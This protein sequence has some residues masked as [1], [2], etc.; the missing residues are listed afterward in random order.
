MTQA[1]QHHQILVE[2]L[3]NPD[4]WPVCAR[5]L[6]V[7]QTHIS[8]VF[9]L[10]DYAYKLKKPLDLG[11][12][13]FSTLKRRK[14]CSEEEI[15]LNSRLAPDVYLAAVPISGSLESPRPEGAGEPIDWLVKMRRF[16]ADEVLAGQPERLDAPLIRQLAHKIA[17]F[18]AR[19]A[20]LG[21][22]TESAEAFGTPEAVWHPV[23]ENFAQLRHFSQDAEIVGPLAELEAHAVAHY[24]RLRPL[25]EERRAEGH[26][27]ECHGD[28]HL[29]NIVLEQG[30]PLIFDGIEFSPGLRWIDTLNDLAFLLMDLRHVGRADLEN[31]ALD[32]Y[33]ETSGDYLGLPLLPFYMAYRAMVRAKV[34]AIRLSQ[35]DLAGEQQQQLKKECLAYL[36]LARDC[37]HPNPGAIWINHGLSG[38]GKSYCAR[39]LP[40]PLPLVRLCSDIERKRLAGLAPTERARAEI[41]GGL[42]GPEMGRRTFERLLAC[43]RAVALAGRIA[44]VDATFIRRNWRTGFRALAESLGVRFVILS[45]SA[46]EAELECRICERMEQGRDASD[47]TLEVLRSQQ[48]NLEPLSP[49]EAAL[50]IQIPRNISLEEL[51]GDALLGGIYPHQSERT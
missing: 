42:Y 20:R 45:F 27:R 23:G 18:H 29:G 43:A 32:A 51:F 14:F 37:A 6:E 9:L 4:C 44:L 12:L 26:I 46:P 39:Q 16:A 50:S 38:S 8:T 28:L 19:V 33:L 11:F 22:A 40:G 34:S 41:G 10:D 35:P 21:S 2:A 48:R 5:R 36:A 31:I 13:D 47:A 30:E 49:E 15:R 3:R 1:Q 24:E 7:R 25:L 17:D